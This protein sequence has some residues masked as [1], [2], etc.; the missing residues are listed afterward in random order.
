M[1]SQMHHPL[2][3]DRATLVWLLSDYENSLPEAV[4]VNAK[5]YAEGHDVKRIAELHQIS[6]PRVYQTLRLAADRLT[7]LA[8]RDRIV[9]PFDSAPT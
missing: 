7:R 4:R 6:E 2:L 1:P 3:R 8:H 9:L 5:A